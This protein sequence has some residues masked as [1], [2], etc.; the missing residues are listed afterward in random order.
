MAGPTTSAPASRTMSSN[1]AAMKI[2]SSTIRTRCDCK[3][4]TLART[5]RLVWNNDNASLK[6]WFDVKD[7]WFMRSNG[8]LPSGWGRRRELI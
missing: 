2:S 7:N 5:W 1:S 8:G 6:E 3:F 4:K